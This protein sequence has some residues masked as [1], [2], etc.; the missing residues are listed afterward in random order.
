MGKGKGNVSHW[1]QSVKP[2][3]I[4]LELDVSSKTLAKIALK[5]ISYNLPFKTKIITD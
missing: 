1:V 3:S 2:N 4:I 5:S